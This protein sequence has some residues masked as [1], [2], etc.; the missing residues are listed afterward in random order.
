[1][2]SISFPSQDQIQKGRLQQLRTG[3]LEWIE[4]NQAARELIKKAESQIEFSLTGNIKDNVMGFCLC[5]RDRKKARKNVGHKMQETGNLVIQVLE[6]SAT[7]WHSCLCIHREVLCLHHLIHRIQTQ[8]LCDN[9]RNLSEPGGL[10]HSIRHKLL[11]IR[12]S[13]SYWFYN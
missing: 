3:S 2:F 11:I 1:M 7:L 4:R 12:L 8:R 6:K 5:V 13:N 9:G 10:F